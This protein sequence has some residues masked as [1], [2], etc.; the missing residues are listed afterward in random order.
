[1]KHLSTFLAILSVLTVNVAMAQEV[2]V[3]VAQG[4]ALDF[5]KSQTDGTKRVK[6]ADVAP[7]VSLAYTSKSADKT[8]FYVFNAGEDDGFVIIGG[9]EAAREI[10]G[11]C[12]HGSFDYDTAPENFK[13]WLGQYTEQIAQAE[14]AGVTGARR[15]KAATNRAN[16]DPLISVKWGQD[17]PFNNKIVGISADNQESTG[18]V[19]GC[20]ATAMAQVM[21]FWQCPT[22]GQGSYSYEYNGLT[23]SA[24]FGNT[25]YDWANMLQTYSK[26]AT[27]E[28]ADAVA[29]LM[30]HAGVSVDMAYGTDASGA[31]SEDIGY[32]LATY[33]GYDKSVRNEF[34]DYYSNAKKVTPFYIVVVLQLAATNSFAMVMTNRTK[35]SRSTG[36]GMA[37]ATE[38]IP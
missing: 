2:S 31:N 17:E 35:C 6:G 14:K 36:A 22:Q 5:L 24:N 37:G 21:K 11:Y 25:T 3:E 33:F 38:A 26:T 15:A 23:F 13:W 18:F 30:F 32:A 29:T 9:D 28:T 27:G 19:T 7:Q 34:R 16:I 10:L 20:V 12:D 4:R 8:C 1:M